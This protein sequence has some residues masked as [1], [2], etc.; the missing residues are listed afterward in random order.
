[1]YNRLGITLWSGQGLQIGERLQAR[2]LQQ[3]Y[4][5]SRMGAPRVGQM[6]LMTFGRPLQMDRR[7]SIAT[8]RRYFSMGDDRPWYEALFEHIET[9]S[10][11]LSPMVLQILEMSFEQQRAGWQ[12]MD[13]RQREQAYMAMISDV[14]GS[15]T[16]GSADFYKDPKAREWVRRQ[17]NQLPS[18]EKD[19]ILL[20]VSEG[21]EDLAAKLEMVLSGKGEWFK[22]PVWILAAGALAIGAIGLIVYAVKS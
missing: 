12:R 3:A 8:Q 14:V 1:M 19:K 9:M 17:F 7:P 4:Y 15:K 21:N 11:Q 2:G 6:G 10:I 13:D 22:N 18:G 16:G 20:D 5:P